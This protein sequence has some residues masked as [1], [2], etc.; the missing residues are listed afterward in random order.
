MKD[1]SDEIVKQLNRLANDRSLAPIARNKIRDA[2]QHIKDMHQQ[3]TDL[4][5]DIEMDNTETQF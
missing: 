5:L 1:R 3:M 2:V 4:I